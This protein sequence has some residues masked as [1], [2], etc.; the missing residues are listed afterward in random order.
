MSSI[1]LALIEQ[2]LVQVFKLLLNNPKFAKGTS[3]TL[4]ATQVQS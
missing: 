1:S 3:E 4:S 2:K